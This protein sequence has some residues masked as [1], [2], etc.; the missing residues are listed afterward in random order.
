MNDLLEL[1]L[2]GMEFATYPTFERF[3]IFVDDLNHLYEYVTEDEFI[4]EAMQDRKKS[5][6]QKITSVNGPL[7]A[8]RDTTNDV[9]QVYGDLTDAGGTFIKSIWDFTMKAISLAVKVLRYIITNI[10][11]IP[12]GIID[13]AKTFASIPSEIRRKIR[14]DIYLYITVEDLTNLHKVIIPQIDKFVSN[15][16]ELSRGTVWG[17]FFHRRAISEKGIGKIIF[18]E[19]DMKYYGNMKSTYD[20]LK[21]IDFSKT[22]VKI[23]DERVINIYF[24]NEKS[25]K[26]KNADRGMVEQ[27][28]YDALAEVFNIFREQEGYMK[29]IATDFDQ[30]LDLSKMNQN[31]QK[32]D[33]STRKN[34]IEAITMNAKIINII[35]NLTQC[36]IK[37]MNTLRD[38]AKKLLKATKVKRVKTP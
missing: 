34:I 38:V 33:E 35:G 17:T 12:N 5:I 13:L 1:E 8:T 15:A 19:N 29:D 10:S 28:Y 11:K 37:D 14:G 7:K 24:G 2:D 22:L 27:S 21:M 20:R 4:L 9:K 23:S 30:K 25:I 18:T 32:S 6:V 31:F 26:Y 16:Y 36:T 3:D